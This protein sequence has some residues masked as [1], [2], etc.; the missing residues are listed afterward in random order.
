MVDG[1]RK[2]GNEHFFMETS[3]LSKSHITSKELLEEK[4]CRLSTS[5]ALATKIQHLCSP[6]Q[7]LI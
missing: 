4:T 2:R 6:E 5:A 7:I 1:G 3:F